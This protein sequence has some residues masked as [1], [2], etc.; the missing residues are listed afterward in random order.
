M[1]TPLKYLKV[2][3]TTKM[4]L[5]KILLFNIVTLSVSS[6]NVSYA[7][8]GNDDDWGRFDDELDDEEIYG[9]SPEEYRQ[10]VIPEQYIIGL[11][12]ETV[13][14]ASNFI[15]GILQKGGF[16]NATALWHYKTTTLTG[17][18]VAG[19]DDHLYTVLQN[20]PN[21]IFIEPVRHF[22]SQLS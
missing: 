1:K 6:S 14:N 5:L 3:T 19:V 13:S 4:Q 12:S 21:V 16:V 7:N 9:I 2:P 22:G 20:D 15:G 18:T 11:N 10:F 17:A 8:D